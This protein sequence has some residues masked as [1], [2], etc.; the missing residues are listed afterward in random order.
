MR[1]GYIILALTLI[2]APAVAQRED[3]FPVRFASDRIE[4]A[5]DA[6]FHLRLRWTAAG[7]ANVIAYDPESQPAVLANGWACRTFPVNPGTV[8]KQRI[9]HPEFGPTLEGT[10]RGVLRD[11]RRSLELERRVRV[12]LPDKFPD[13]VIFQTTYRNLSSRPL[14]LARVDSLR[15]LLDRRLAEPDAP[16]YAFASFQG[17]AYR[18][19][20]D[21][22]LIRL[23]PGFHQTNFQGL[24]DRT[25][26]EGEGGG[27]PFIDLWSPAMGVALAHIEK[28]PQWV[29]LPVGVRRDGEVEIALTEAPLAKFKQKEYLAP[30]DTYHTVTAAVIFHHGDYYDALRTY[31]NLLRARGVAIPETSPPSAYE[32]YWKSWGFGLE[33]TVERILSLLP[34]L[35]K[36]GIRI[37]NLDDGW[38]DYYGDWNVNRSPGKFPGGEKDIIEFVRKIHARGFKTNLWWYPLG[39]SPGSRLARE[40]P[41]LLVRDENG[42]L[43]RDDR[44]QYQLCPAYE[45][46]LRHIERLLRR[47]VSQWDFDGVYVDS[48]GLTAVPPCFEPS[49][50][51]SS[52]LDSFQALPSVFRLINETLKELKPDP[53][54]EV[55]ICAMPHSPYNMPYYW[56]ANASDPLTPA[57]ARRRIKLEKAIRGPRFAVGDCYQVPLDEWK[58]SS[59]PEAFDSALGT[60]AQMTTF[61]ADLS[62]AQ[63]SDWERWFRLYRELGLASAEYLNLYDIAFDKPE[64]HVVRKG[65]VL[66][67][68][69]FADLWP[70]SRPIELRGLDPARKYEI[71]DYVRGVPLGAVSGKEPRIRHAFRG[72]LL[73]RVKPAD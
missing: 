16:S 33:F 18:W 44:G 31:G 67:Y 22:S 24:D 62:P 57:Q 51:H 42:N 27:I 36:M 32:P 58:G 55:C 63:R 28:K 17:G 8:R 12:L 35:E 45:P 68:G 5:Y 21:Y 49:H 4:V 23:Q 47:F 30:G 43:P 20:R 11:K 52:P 41:E 40:H 13:A 53:Y 71:Y 26:P 14:R 54:F 10:L 38:F 56:I 6:G 2:S 9:D 29:S 46:A 72:S 64:I 73:I 60:G 15:L 66:Y 25:S 1:V 70:S 3:A 48:V 37:A 69:I 50:H 65:D 61:Y 34:E 7:S 39:V 19:G 59:L